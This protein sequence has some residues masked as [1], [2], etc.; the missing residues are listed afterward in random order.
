MM[1]DSYGGSLGILL[2][3]CALVLLI[4]CANVANLLLARGLSRRPQT[5]IRSALGASRRRL[6]RQALTESLLLGA[7]GGVAGILIAFA[8]RGFLFCSP[9]ARQAPFT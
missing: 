9:S 2:G 1:R 3:I 5:A 7:M 6:V 4:A 8:Q